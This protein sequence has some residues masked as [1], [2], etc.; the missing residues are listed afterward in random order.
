MEPNASNVKTFYNNFAEKQR[1]IGI[2]E[3]LLGLCHRLEKHL[4]KRNKELQILELGCGIGDFSRLILKKFKPSLLEGIDISD[5]S[6]AMA[7]KDLPQARFSAL[8]ITIPFE[9]RQKANVITLM[10]VLEHVPEDHHSKV[11]QNI[12]ANSTTDAMLFVNIPNPELIAYEHQHHPDRLQVIDQALDIPQLIQHL[13]QAG[14]RL[15]S[16]ETWTGW[17][18]ND[19]V[20]M[21]FEKKAAFNEQFVAKERS[22]IQKIKHRLYMQIQTLR[23]NR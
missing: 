19:Y 8:D 20:F 22:V 23:Y 9:T 10:D 4:K 13:D 11:F 12:V 5:K 14:F 1:S 17:I 6:V 16:L 2:N 18:K 15:R 21:F 7:A 3:R